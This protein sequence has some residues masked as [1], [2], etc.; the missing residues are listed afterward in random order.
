MIF[1]GQS[2]TFFA[3]LL[4]KVGLEKMK[5]L[6]AT[7]R[8]DKTGTKAREYVTRPDMLGDD[9]MKIEEQWIDWVQNL[10]TEPAF[11][12]SGAPQAK[13]GN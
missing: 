6:I 12:R 3:F 5:A 8:G 4:E 13:Q 2:S 9:Y 7:V 10:Q 11:P 1:D